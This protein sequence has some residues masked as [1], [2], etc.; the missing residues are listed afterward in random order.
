MVQTIY[1][2]LYR[3]DSLETAETKVVSVSYTFS[4]SSFSNLSG[5]FRILHQD[6]LPLTQI[7]FFRRMKT[8]I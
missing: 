4:L 2:D 6:D 7:I 8:G 5:G 1:P 3:V